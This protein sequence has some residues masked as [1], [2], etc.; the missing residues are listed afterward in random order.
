MSSKRKG[1]CRDI[2]ILH[3]V[4]EIQNEDQYFLTI[5]IIISYIARH[6]S[7]EVKKHHGSCSSPYI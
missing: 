1:T 7:D 2:N 4:K 6:M 3:K 5:L